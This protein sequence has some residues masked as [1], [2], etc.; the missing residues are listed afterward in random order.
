MRDMRDALPLERRPT[1]P[2]GAAE[3]DF[4]SFYLEHKVG[5]RPPHH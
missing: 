5:I 2:A 3:A 4:E 1:Q